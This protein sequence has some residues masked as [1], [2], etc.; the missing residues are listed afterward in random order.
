MWLWRVYWNISE[1]SK[2]SYSNQAKLC[3]G[4]AF[5]I[6]EQDAWLGLQINILKTKLLWLTNTK[7]QKRM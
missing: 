1:N 6:Y 5:A 3:T 7:I 2:S 4:Q